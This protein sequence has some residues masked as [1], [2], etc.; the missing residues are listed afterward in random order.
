MN[1]NNNFRQVFGNKPVFGM[2]HLSGEDPVQQAIKE[3]RIF[4]QEGID[5]VIVENYYGSKQ[6]VVKTLDAISCIN[7]KV[8]VGVNVLPN[9]FTESFSLAQKY[10]ARFVQLDYVSGRYFEGTFDSDSYKLIREKFPE[11]LVLGGVHPKY[12]TPLTDSNL[13]F[14]LRQGMQR[15]EA[16]VVTG[17]ET[18]KETPL[19]KIK[20]FR[21]VLGNHSLIIGAGITQKNAYNQLQ[22]ADGVIV[23]TGLK[24]D[25]I[26][27]NPV[28][29]NRVKKLMNVI[30]DLR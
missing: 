21:Q 26:T 5:A 30:R 8:I 16:I 25:G 3:L 2:L 11:I 15:A 17:N 18:G 6:D 20:F 27:Q 24:Y 23:G 7:T 14:D 10:G 9:E 28:E 13:E 22:I 19:H 4:E 1:S 12:Y 29:R